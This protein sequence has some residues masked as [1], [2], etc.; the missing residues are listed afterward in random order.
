MRSIA[1][2]R[3]VRAGAW[4][5][6]RLS[7]R[8]KEGS[9]LVRVSRWLRLFQ[10]V[11]RGTHVLYQH[12][13]RITTGQSSRARYFRRKMTDVALEI[14]FLPPNNGERVLLEIVRHVYATSYRY[15]CDW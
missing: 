1:V 10:T 9:S 7:L 6:L 14:S 11:L 12:R 13:P 2:E 8:S 5:S 3:C 15:C 4:L